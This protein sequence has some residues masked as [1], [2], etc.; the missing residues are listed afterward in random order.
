MGT[1][2][3][4][5]GLLFVALALATAGCSSDSGTP[6]SQGSAGEVVEITIANFAFDPSEVAVEVG[7]VVRWT[8]DQSV[9]H[10]VTSSD[11]LWDAT[12]SSGGTFE[13]TV[14]ESGTLPYFCAIHPSMTATLDGSG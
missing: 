3:R 1:A 11:G 7:D 14:T 13:Y 8:N 4:I 10:T 2:Q 9:T 5:T 6:T 12:V